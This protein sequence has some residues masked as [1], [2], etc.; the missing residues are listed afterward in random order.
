[1]FWFQLFLF[2]GFWVLLLAENHHYTYISL[3]F[4]AISLAI[5]F[6]LSLKRHLLVLFGVL[7]GLL[8]LHGYYFTTSY[9]NTVLFLLYVFLV[10][11]FYLDKGNFRLYVII[12]SMFVFVLCLLKM[13]AIYGVIFFHLMLYYVLCQFKYLHHDR[14]E[15]QEKYNQ[16]K[17]R[18]RQM[19]RTHLKAEKAARLEERTRIARDIHDSVGHQLTALMMKLEML[20]IQEKN[21]TYRDLKQMVTESLQETRKAVQA[22]QL[23]EYEGI[24]AVI[25]LIRKLEA[26]SHLEVQ[27][28]LKRGVLNLSLTN[29]VGV[30]LYRV[31][32]EA[33]T[34]AMRHAEAREVQVILGTTAD[35]QLSFTIQNSI[36]DT[37][38]WEYGFG[39]KTMRKRVESL[40]G[41]VNIYQTENMFIVSGMLP[42]T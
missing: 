1:M 29:E 25:Q 31:I 38:L 19:K 9:T 13:E 23:D 15:Q 41:K 4:F 6:L 16:L 10:A 22:L 24:A 28:T 14:L 12:H 2:C 42:S 5:W 40:K 35:N 34:N 18:Y 7:G 21:D 36:L 30:G 26:E 17:T 3:M 32:Q 39:L 8:T 33:L 37:N 27:F 11:V 20:A